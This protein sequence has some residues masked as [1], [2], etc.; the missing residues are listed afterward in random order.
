LSNR[1]SAAAIQKHLNAACQCPSG[2]LR[3]EY[4]IFDH[5][6]LFR[7][8][9]PRSRHVTFKV[10]MEDLQGDPNEL[11]LQHLDAVVDEARKLLSA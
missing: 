8:D 4:R 9:L 3:E 5:G 6:M 7:Y 1:I 11:T 2:V 10:P